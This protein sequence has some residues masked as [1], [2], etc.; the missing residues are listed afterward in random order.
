MFLCR[1][2]FGLRRVVRNLPRIS[3]LLVISRF[4]G[5]WSLDIWQSHRS[6]V[7]RAEGPAES[8]HAREGVV[9]DTDKM[10]G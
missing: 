9:R 3:L 7:K 2:I 8:S 6:A 1:E 4:Q 5:A 10:E